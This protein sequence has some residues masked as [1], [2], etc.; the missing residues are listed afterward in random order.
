L[1]IADGVRLLGKRYDIPQLLKSFDI[2]LFNSFH[3]GMSNAVLEAMAAGIPV[4]ASDIPANRQLI[5]SG[6]DGLLVK[7]TD[8]AMIAA[9]LE[10]LA[11]DRMYADKLAASALARVR[12][13]H[14]FGPMIKKITALLNDI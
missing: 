7:S 12:R 8:P 13:E 2:F 3:E 14:D 1:G 6:T 11:G 5:V 9:A 10:T 4:V